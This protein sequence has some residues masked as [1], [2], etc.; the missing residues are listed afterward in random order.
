VEHLF[1]PRNVIERG[2]GYWLKRSALGESFEQRG[3]R[4]ELRRRVI[5]LAV[6]A[7]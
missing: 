7:E 4:I 1:S 5:F 6:K 2:A 3:G